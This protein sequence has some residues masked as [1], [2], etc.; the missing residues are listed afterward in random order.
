MS[1]II[2]YVWLTTKPSCEGG[3]HFPCLLWC[4]YHMSYSCFTTTDS[5]GPQYNVRYLYAGTPGR[6][7][8]EPTAALGILLGCSKT[9]HLTFMEMFRIQKL[10][11]RVNVWYIL[12]W[13]LLKGIHAH[14]KSLGYKSGLSAA[15]KKSNNVSPTHGNPKA[16]GCVKLCLYVHL[17]LPLWN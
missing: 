13:I 3:L 16:G 17:S 10:T 7:R 9:F 15:S 11:Q 12:G 4:F 1:F 8:T 6:V 2:C 14:E 5:G